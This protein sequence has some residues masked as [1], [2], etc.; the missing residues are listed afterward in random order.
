MLFDI[1]GSELLN[2][3]RRS[4][5]GGCKQCFS[6][7]K[8][9]KKKK[10]RLLS[11]N[12]WTTTHHIIN[13]MSLSSWEWLTYFG[14]LMKP[15]GEYLVGKTSG[16]QK[17][18]ESCN[19]QVR[20]AS[21]LIF[22]TPSLCIFK[23]ISTFKLSS[24]KPA[25]SAVWLLSVPSWCYQ[26]DLRWGRA[27]RVSRFQCTVVEIINDRGCTPEK[28]VIISSL[29]CPLSSAISSYLKNWD[30]ISATCKCFIECNKIHHFN[31][32]CFSGPAHRTVI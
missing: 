24:A 25:V 13:T 18:M 16:N 22:V 3:L 31:S 32:D 11:I 26:A 14:I 1:W 9:K 7:K 30:V 15:I 21:I 2:S 20:T 5:V 29:Q 17:S 12:G 10:G 19:I 8:K 6:I 28:T 23:C 27:V 4:A